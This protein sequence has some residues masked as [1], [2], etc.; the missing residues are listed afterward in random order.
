[1]QSKREVM[2]QLLFNNT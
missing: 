2:K 1:M